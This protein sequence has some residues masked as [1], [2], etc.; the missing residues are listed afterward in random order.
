M[1]ESRDEHHPRDIRRIKQIGRA[2][3]AMSRLLP[4]ECKCLVQAL[5]AKTMLGRRNIASTLYLGVAKSEN[6]SLKAHAWV[7]AGSVV[8]TG[9]IGL[10]A[11]TIVARFS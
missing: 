10:S 5:T 11:Y 9:E 1:A 2:V 7:R 3:A 4:W 6:R 8:V